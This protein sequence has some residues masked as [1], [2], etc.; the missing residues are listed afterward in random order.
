MDIGEAEGDSGRPTTGTGFFAFLADPRVSGKRVEGRR[1][2]EGDR[3]GNG[4]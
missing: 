3:T 4:L 2:T 1:V